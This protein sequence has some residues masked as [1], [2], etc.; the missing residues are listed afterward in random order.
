MSIASKYNK[1]HKFDFTIPKDFKYKS[2]HDLYN[3]HGENYTHLVMSM[4]ISNKGKFGDSS[5]IATP[6]ELVNLPK[7]LN[8]TV[9]TMLNDDE[10]ITAINSHKLGFKIYTY[11]VGNNV[12]YSINWVDC[13]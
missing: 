7:H 1:N 8:D 10:C 12:Y 4:Y 5:V 11:D 2:L 9:K 3:N 6:Y 13:K